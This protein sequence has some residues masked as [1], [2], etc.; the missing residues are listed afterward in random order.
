MDEHA[1]AAVDELLLKLVERWL[2]GQGG[3]GEGEQ[4][5]GEEAAADSGTESCFHR[6][7]FLRFGGQS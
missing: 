7:G 2:L 1:E 5:E 4:H 6:S 3:K